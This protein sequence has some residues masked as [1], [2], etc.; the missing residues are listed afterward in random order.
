[1]ERLRA[2]EIFSNAMLTLVAVESVDLRHDKTD[3]G[4][5]LYGRVEPIAV[6]VCRLDGTYALDL[7]ARRT[8]LEHLSRNVPELDTLIARLRNYGDS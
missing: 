1:M 3:N 7:A 4:C 8:D 5:R 2:R 6:I